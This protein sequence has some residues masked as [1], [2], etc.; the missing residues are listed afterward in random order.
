[1]DFSS[2]DYAAFIAYAGPPLLIDSQ[3]TGSD[4]S[5]LTIR[6]EYITKCDEFCKQYFGPYPKYDVRAKFYRQFIEW[7]RI[8]QQMLDTEDVHLDLMTYE[9]WENRSGRQNRKD[10]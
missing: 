1:M 9:V 8:R 4:P 2:N 3:R 5:A 10:T 7:Y 6:L